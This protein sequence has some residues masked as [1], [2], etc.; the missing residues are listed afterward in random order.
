MDGP[1]VT[2]GQQ[3]LV[4]YPRQL[5][6]ARRVIAAV[7]GQEAVLLDTS[8]AAEGEAQRLIDFACGGMEALEAQVHRISAEVFLFA[9]AQARVEPAN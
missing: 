8:H 9:P 6:D 2:G 4:F 1:T 3:L 5:D 7:Q